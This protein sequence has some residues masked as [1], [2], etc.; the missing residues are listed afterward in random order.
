[1][2][3]ASRSVGT[4]RCSYRK[5]PS[6]RCEGG[7]SPQLAE[8][9]VVRPCGVKP[10]PGPAG[11]PSL[12]VTHF[13]TPVSRCALLQPP[14]SAV[15]FPLRLTGVFCCF[16]S[17]AKPPQQEKLVLI[18]VCV[19]AAV[20]VLVAVVSALLAVRRTVYTAR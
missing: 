16:P 10:S 5:V 20:V 8:Q 9:T 12:E 15:G 17:T 2:Q 14:P 11:G 13:D 7:F 1:M 19:G 6:D 18:L 4:V 3:G